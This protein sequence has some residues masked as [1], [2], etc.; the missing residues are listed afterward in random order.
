MSLKFS[1]SGRPMVECINPE[2]RKLHSIFRRGDYVQ[3]A[4]TK[5]VCRSCGTKW[6]LNDDD[7]KK[8]QEHYEQRQVELEA[9]KQ[10]KNRKNQEKNKQIQTNKQTEKKIVPPEKQSKP[11][12]KKK[13]WLDDLLS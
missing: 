9:R 5:V 2:C 13:G 8:L 11:Q 12:Q 3:K 4:Q 7:K 10:E 1:T 6:I